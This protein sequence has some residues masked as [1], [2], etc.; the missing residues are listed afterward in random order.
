MLPL[1]ILENIFKN[2]YL[3]EDKIN[4]ERCFDVK[5]VRKKLVIDKSFE[6]GLEILIWFKFYLFIYFEDPDEVEKVVDMIFYNG[7][8]KVRTRN[9]RFQKIFSYNP[10]SY[11]IIES[12]LAKYLNIDFKLFGRINRNIL[13][14]S[15]IKL[16]KGY[17]YYHVHPFK[18]YT[19]FL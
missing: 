8:W 1:E 7:N 16:I 5:R 10:K 19:F 11:K 12:L 15:Q 3:L 14:N 18:H 2:M 4:F 17:P 13:L 6:L 9:G